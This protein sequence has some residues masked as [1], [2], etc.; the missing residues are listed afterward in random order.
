MIGFR[1]ADTGHN[2]EEMV[3]KP[4]A[5]LLKCLG[6][7]VTSLVELSGMQCAV[8]SIPISKVGTISG[9]ESWGLGC[10]CSASI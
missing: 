5:L 2:Q 4:C 1:K 10:I 6:A 9:K 7:R 3:F 8:W